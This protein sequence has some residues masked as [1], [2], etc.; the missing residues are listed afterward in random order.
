MNST[1]HVCVAFAEVAPPKDKLISRPATAT[2][3]IALVLPSPKF[4]QR[5]LSLGPPPPGFNRRLRLGIYVVF[6][7]LATWGTSTALLA[8]CEP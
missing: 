1:L 8:L 6:G 7:H 4:E 3:P 5:Q 2:F